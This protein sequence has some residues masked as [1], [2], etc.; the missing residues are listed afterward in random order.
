M[1]SFI[2]ASLLTL[3][4]V[5]S[6]WAAGTSSL[7][8][9][10]QRWAQINYQMEDDAKEAA[11]N[12]L[13]IKAQELVNAEP[14]NPDDLIWLGII[15]S[16]TAGAKGG[17]G[18]L[19]LAKAAKKSFE[20]AITINP[21]A[22]SGSAMTSLGVLYHKVPGWPIG[23][24]SDKKAK[25][26]LVQSYKLNPTSID[27]NYFLAEFL[28]DDGDYEGAKQHL[29]KAQKAAPRPTRPIADIG[30]HKEV[31]ALM[32]KVNQKL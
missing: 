10:Q 28:Y 32:E 3:G 8:E 4:L 5:S 11:F 30:R 17:L 19:S 9:I 23:F 18:A 24:G 12:D 26:L 29:E 15:Q 22:L 2:T 31:D 27:S 20:D 14:N 7:L 16:S 13:A 21:S 6:T 25:E 1:K